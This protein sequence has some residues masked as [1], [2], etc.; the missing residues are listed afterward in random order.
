MSFL[1]HS[2]M[3]LLVFGPTVYGYRCTRSLILGLENPWK[4]FSYFPW[5]EVWC[6]F[7]QHTWASSGAPDTWPT[8]NTHNSVP[9]KNDS[10][11]R[12]TK[13]KAPLTPPIPPSFKSLSNQSHIL[14]ELVPFKTHP[15][16]AADVFWSPV[17]G[18]ACAVRRRGLWRT[19]V[20]LTSVTEVERVCV[21]YKIF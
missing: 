1:N 14:V 9:F 7:M 20:E 12:N 11:E 13:V 17:R 18:R 15:H 10:H 5:G 4:C 16:P 2:L 6:D 8:N 19:C 21:Q 3:L